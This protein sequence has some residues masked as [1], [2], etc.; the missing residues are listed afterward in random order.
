MWRRDRYQPLR[1]DLGE[2][3]DPAVRE[4]LEHHLQSRI[5]ENLARGLTRAEAEAEARRRF[6]DLDRYRRETGAEER[7]VRGFQGRRER[8]AVARQEI[9][10]AARALRRNPRFSLTAILTLAVGIGGVAAV[11]ALLDA[12]VLR[13]LPYPAADRLVRLYHPVPKVGPNDRW[14]LAAAEYFHFRKEA[15]SLETVALFGTLRSTVLANG[16][17][18]QVSAGLVTETLLPL[19]GARPALG[20]LFTAEDILPGHNN[21]IL[22][23][24]FW[25]R[26]YGG[27]ADV[28]GSTIR[29]EGTDCIVVGVAAGAVDLPD[30]TVDVWATYG[31]DPAAEARNNHVYRAVA[32][33]APGATAASATRELSAMIATYPERFPSAYSTAFVDRT[34]FTSLAVPWK[35]DVV[36][37]ATG[38]IWLVFAAAALV[39]LIAA[40]NVANLF[41]VRSQAVRREVGV[42]VMLGAGRSQLAWHHLAESGLIAL[43]SLVL[44]VG[45]ARLGLAAFTSAVPAGIARGA[46][47]T[48]PRLAEVAL[49]WRA[50]GLAAALAL[51][52]FLVLGLVPVLAAP[53][54]GDVRTRGG[55]GTRREGWLRNGL[56]VAQVAFAMMLLAAAGLMLRTFESLR[57]IAPGF[58]TEGVF[59][60]NVALP[61]GS[62]R[63]YE[64]TTRFY[65]DMVAQV[66]A[67]PGVELAAVGSDLPIEA[68]DGCSVFE[69][70]DRPAEVEITCIP[71]AVVGPN[72]FSVLG[73]SVEGRDLT[74]ADLDDNSG[75]VV[76][77]DVLARRLFADQALGRAVNGPSGKEQTPFRVTGVARDLRWQRLD[78]PPE[79]VAFFPLQPIPG[80]WLWS[81]PARMYLVARVSGADPTVIAPAVQRIV[82]AIDP[83]VAVERPRSMD[84]VVA[85]SLLR[86]RLIM[87]L[88]ALSAAAALLLSVVGL[89]GVVSYSV[90]RRT[91][92]IGVRIAVGAPIRQVRG[93]VVRQALVL[94]GAGLA[95]GTGGAVLIGRV[96]RSLLFGVSP[97]DPLTLASVMVLLLGV[98]AAAS[99][100][101]AARAAAVDPVTAL[102]AE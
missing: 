69:Y 34:G 44:A 21:V 31:L 2:E 76:L 89:Y 51:L 12:V 5:E 43:A 32:R 50:V 35:D 96:M 27:A 68:G 49:G 67:L 28:I 83:E 18:L 66:E 92:E 93:A 82:A 23:E 6:G 54:A 55:T 20:R 90:A 42:R 9:R 79:E 1:D 7:R 53:E 75:A 77:S 15:R 99:L 22:S 4:E 14:N 94:T 36:G 52:A 30:W 3:V 45:L 48:V 62:Y 57:N 71:N 91:R 56:V 95:I 25:R 81:P 101:P 85:A 26:Q 72:Y 29:L 37:D 46:A 17:S 80:A 60:A 11:F 41:L 24:R 61:F 78:Q 64:Q 87:I 13:P 16:T 84:Q 40:V 98:A 59:V 70:P 8:F 102:R 38:I 100:G 86:I 74:W 33:L 10:R 97:G 19:L 47:V 73:V 58:R 65:R 63:R 39:L 88:L